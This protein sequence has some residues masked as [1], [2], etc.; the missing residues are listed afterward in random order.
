MIDNNRPTASD[1]WF[2]VRF[3]AGVAVIATLAVVFGYAAAVMT[4]HAW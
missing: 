2:A 1:V 3:F 4:G